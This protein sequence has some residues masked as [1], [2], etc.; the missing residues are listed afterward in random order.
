MSGEDRIIDMARALARAIQMDERY[1][2]FSEARDAS[3]A[4]KALQDA[5]GRFNVARMNLNEE[6][7]KTE[8]D[9]PKVAKYNEDMRRAYEE[10][11]ASET[12]SAY[13]SAHDDINKLLM[14]ITA[15]LSGA[16]NGE[17]PDEITEPSGC[18]DGCDSCE[19]CH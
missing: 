3:D 5:I 19:G 13:E 7:S 2:A 17:D 8:Q 10:V 12:M 6:I 18:A 4:D 16:I 14:Y 11:K 15:I 9:G 1:K